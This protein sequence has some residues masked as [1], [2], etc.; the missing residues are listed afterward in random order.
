VRSDVLFRHCKGHAQNALNRLNNQ[1]QQNQINNQQQ[2]QQLPQN[3]G[4]DKST[5]R[6][7]SQTEAGLNGAPTP[8][9]QHETTLSPLSRRR[10]SQQVPQANGEKSQTSNPSPSINVRHPSLPQQTASPNDSRI[11]ALI[12]AA[13]HLEPPTEVA[14]QSPS[15][16]HISGEHERYLAR[17]QENMPPPIDPAIDMLSFSPAGHVSS[18]DQWAFELVQSN[19]PLPNRT[20][21]DAL[22]TWLFPLES[23]L[24]TNGSH[25]MHMDGHFENDGF[26]HPADNQ[27]SPSGSSASIASRIPRERFARVESC[28]PAKSRKAARLMPTLWQSLISCECTNILS[29]VSPGAAETPISE[30]E[31]RSSRWGLDEECRDLLQGAINSAPPALPIFRSESYGDTASSSGEAGASPGVEGIQFPPAEILDIA[32]EMYLYYFHPTLPI[33]HIPTFSA[34]NAPRPLLLTMCL[35]GLSILGT[36]GASKFVSRTL[37]VR[38]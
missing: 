26:R 38:D 20:P 28:W 2:Q 15:P 19:H 27:A 33:I 17:S 25:H 23:D 36:A 35:I 9:L 7:T 30:R 5:P 6:S 4:D 22:Q 1:Q 29:E 34:K 16:I 14:W 3:P 24:L 18:L 32:L 8:Q 31:R 37:P 13:Q 11:E 10:D 12:N 21:A